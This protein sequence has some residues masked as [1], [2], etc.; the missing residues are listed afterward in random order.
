MQIECTALLILMNNV[1]SMFCI[2]CASECA[3]VLVTG[4]CACS[5]QFLDGK[6]AAALWRVSNCA[7]HTSEFAHTQGDGSHRS[8]EAAP[9]AAC[10]YHTCIFKLPQLSS[11]SPL[12]TLDILPLSAPCDVRMGSVTLSRLALRQDPQT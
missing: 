4:V 3:C 12:N 5:S 8:A 10:C 7:P 1:K 9:P 2:Q 11:L 6:C